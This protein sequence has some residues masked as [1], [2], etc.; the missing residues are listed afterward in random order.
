MSPSTMSYVQQPNSA[1]A[2]PSRSR[3]QFVYVDVANGVSTVPRQLIRSHAA[4]DHSIQ[5]SHEARLARLRAQRAAARARL[6]ADNKLQQQEEERACQ[7]QDLLDV[8]DD[9]SAC[10]EVSYDRVW[11]GQG[12]GLTAGETSLP[13]D[14]DILLDAELCTRQVMSFPIPISSSRLISLID[15]F[16]SLPVKITT[17]WMDSILH[18]CQCTA[19]RG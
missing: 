14:S 13:T 9:G 12:A 16:D 15:P 2:I 18:N 17:R 7:S 19:A 4:S 1:G 10:V 3:L 11:R 6:R 5:E 8:Q